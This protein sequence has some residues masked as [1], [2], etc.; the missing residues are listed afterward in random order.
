MIN[1]IPKLQH[2]AVEGIKICNESTYV[3]FHLLLCELLFR[4]KDSLERLRN[5]K[6]ESLTV[7]EILE[8]L[9]RVQVMGHYLKTMARS[10]AIETHLQSISNSLIVD[11]NKLWMPPKPEEVN[12]TYFVDFQRFKP[13][14]PILYTKRQ[15]NITL[16]VI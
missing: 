16:G 5:L 13:F 4:L 3:E 12:D 14:R 9:I 10:A 6:G 7:E 8:H 2:A 15:T 11:I 1:K